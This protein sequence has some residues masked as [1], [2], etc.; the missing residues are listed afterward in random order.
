MLYSFLTTD[1]NE[2]VKP[3]HAK[4]MPVILTTAEEADAWLTAPM[5]D[6]LKPQRPLPAG[7]LK[8]VARGEKKDA[9]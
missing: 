4:A 2:D 9:M 6:A 1:S 3:V 5:A 8:I 7:A